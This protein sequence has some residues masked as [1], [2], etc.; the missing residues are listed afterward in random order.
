MA[1]SIFPQDSNIAF[2]TGTHKVECFDNKTLLKGGSLLE[3]D[4]LAIFERLLEQDITAF[5]FFAPSE[6]S[7]IDESLTKGEDDIDFNNLAQTLND[8][9]AEDAST[10][11]YLPEV[12]NSYFASYSLKVRQSTLGRSWLT[13]PWYGAMG[14][15]LP[16]ARVVAQR[17]GKSGTSTKK[18]DMHTLLC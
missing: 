13:N 18:W 1:T 12:G 10:Y 4:L 17:M 15:A 9:Q 2:G 7:L 8:L 3:K 6:V 16:Y 14:T 5:D 11:V